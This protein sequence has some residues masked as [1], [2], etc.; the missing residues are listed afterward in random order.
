MEM[1]VGAKSDVGLKRSHN[2]DAFCVDSLLGLYVV[3]DGMGGGNAGE[4]ASALAVEA[5][6]K[7]VLEGAQNDDVPLQGGCDGTVLPQTNRLASAIRVANDLIHREAQ[8]QVNRTGMGSTVVAA[9]V[10]GEVVSLAHVGDSRLYLIREQRIQ[11]LTADHS[12]IMEQVRQGLMTED[13]AERSPQRHIVTR[14]LGV[15]PSV[16]VEL[17]EVPVRSGDRL[18]LCTDGLTRRVTPSDIRKAARIDD[19]P[20][21]LAD[22]LIWMAN[23]AGGDDNTTVV[24]V[25]FE[26]GDRPTFWRRLR[27]RW[28]NQGE[29]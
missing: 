16:E 4:V 15:E 25:V 19:D 9:F 6:H 20:Q 18:L 2:E 8:Q 22:R 14:A 29:R 10:H 28:L 21:A 13:E 5:I 1:R 11:P 24:I 17:G 23:A 3:C 7:H 12:L 27:N 26:E